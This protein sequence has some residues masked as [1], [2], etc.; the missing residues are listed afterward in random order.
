MNIT[1]GGCINYEALVVLR[2]L[3]IDDCGTESGQALGRGPTPPARPAWAG[4]RASP[5]EAE[6]TL[7]DGT[8]KGS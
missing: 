5:G 2:G 6:A 7:G 1:C 4:G 3:R 8:E